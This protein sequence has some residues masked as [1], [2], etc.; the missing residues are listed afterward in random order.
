M[1][2]ECSSLLA[3]YFQKEGIDYQLVPARQ[4]QWNAAE[5]VICT[6]KNH[7]IA[8]LCMTDSNFPLH[9][10]NCLIQQAVLTLNFMQGSQIN[11]S[12]SA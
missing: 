11:P 8:G 10:W 9:L 2:N 4:H 1:D 7:L 3:E 5:R 12:L 6:F